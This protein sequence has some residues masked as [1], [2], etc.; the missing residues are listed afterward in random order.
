MPLHCI[1]TVTVMT[2]V[3][4]GWAQRH[5]MLKLNLTRGLYARSIIL[6]AT[7]HKHVPKEHTCPSCNVRHQLFIYPSVLGVA[8][9]LIAT[10]K[11]CVRSQ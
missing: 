6:K 1:V 7:L 9:L 2:S 4:K 5:A 3:Y 11:S 10:D 8:D